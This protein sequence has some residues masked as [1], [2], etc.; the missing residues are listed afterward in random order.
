MTASSLRHHIRRL[1]EDIP[2]RTEEDVK[3]KKQ[4]SLVSEDGSASTSKG[5][6]YV[7]YIVSL[8]SSLH[9]HD[10]L[11]TYFILSPTTADQKI[12]SKATKLAKSK[13]LRPNSESLADDG[14]K[15]SN[16]KDF[17]KERRSL[18]LVS[19]CKYFLDSLERAL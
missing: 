10:A 6:R 17:A 5:S 3:L 11:L 8:P 13:M 9:V 1:P 12:L 7:S 19:L 2:I 15:S 4:L 18:A 16:S 14:G